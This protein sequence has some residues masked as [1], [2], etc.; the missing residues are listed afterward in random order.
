LSKHI[1][2]QPTR[3]IGL[4]YPA[5]PMP[6][7]DVRQPATTISFPEQTVFVGTEA[8]PTM[9]QKFKQQFPTLKKVL[10]VTDQGVVKAGLSA[11]LTSSLQ[12]QG[13]ES[14]VWDGT[15][16]NPTTDNSVDI[17]L[18]FLKNSC[19]LVIG[20][21][22]GGPMDA[23]KAGMAL[24]ANQKRNSQFNISSSG[25][26]FLVNELRQLCFKQMDP[27]FA[28]G[29]PPMV[30]IP[31][32]AG[33]GSEGGKSAVITA[34]EGFK[35][36]FGHPVFFSKLVALVPQFTEKLP[37]PLTAATGIDA[38]FH[39]TEAYF[40]THEAGIKDGLS[41]PQIDQCDAFSIDGV[42]RILANIGKAF[43][44]GSDLDA[45][46]QMQIAAFYGAKA[47]RKGD[48]GGVHA[49]GH[50]IGATYH[51]H[52]GTSIARMSVPVLK[53]NEEESKDH[54]ET[55]QK[56]ETML[57]IYNSHGIKGKKLHECVGKLL[58]SLNLPIGLTGLNIS[59]KAELEKLADLASKDPCQTNPVKLDY[60]KYLQIFDMANKPF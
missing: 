19:G 47:F 17:A 14:V 38:L 54:T 4:T 21:G 2:P 60:K 56:F 58:K 27:N 51:L 15:H 16:S 11:S 41:P 44:N 46:L 24:V 29:V 13:L 35:F 25:A 18:T 26:N 34:P 10:I 28:S 12:K 23:M 48:L 59:S 9:L 36:V 37:P 3:K 40:V 8:L 50:A 33:T 53:F 32:T 1:R 39:L 30:C 20:L 49:T 42:N 45:R 31:T 22:G 55:K 43:Q 52:H 5:W 6:P 57:Q 7:T